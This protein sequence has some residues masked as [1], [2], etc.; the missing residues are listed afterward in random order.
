MKLYEPGLDVEIHWNESNVSHI[1]CNRRVEAALQMIAN[2]QRSNENEP[3]LT[4]ETHR[5][6]DED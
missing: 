5:F 1:T 6:N 3:I 2:I 4:C